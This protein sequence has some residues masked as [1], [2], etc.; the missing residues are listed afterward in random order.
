MFLLQCHGVTKGVYNFLIMVL[1]EWYLIIGFYVLLVVPIV[2]GIFQ[3]ISWLNNQKPFGTN[4]ANPPSSASTKS[5]QVQG[6]VQ[7]ERGVVKHGVAPV[8]L[9][10]SAS[11]LVISD[12]GIHGVWH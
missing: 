3:W 8:H 11:C 4:V 7:N 5:H 10:F 6:Q 12:S 9:H 2:L 1:F